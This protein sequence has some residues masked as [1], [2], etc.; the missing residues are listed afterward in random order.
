[1]ATIKNKHTGKLAGCE[2]YQRLNEW[3][4]EQGYNPDN[5]EVILSA[6]EQ[7][8]VNREEKFKGIEFEGV[9]CSACSEDQHGLSS[10]QTRFALA[11]MQGKK[12]PA[13]NF[14][15]HNGNQLVLSPDNIDAFEATWLP[16]RMKFFPMP[17]PS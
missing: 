3:F 15:F 10:I 8:E 11:K 16:F 17:E 9:M 13:I 1:M 2:S 12:H 5:F 4:Q 14:H 7:K 6:D